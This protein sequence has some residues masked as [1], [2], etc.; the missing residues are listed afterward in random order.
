M[1]IAALVAIGL[2]I[3]ESVAPAYLPTGGFLNAV[4][5]PVIPMIVLALALLFVPGLRSLEDSKDPLA[6]V[7]PPTPP[8][9]ASARAPTMDRIIRTLWWAFLAVFVVSMLTWMPVLW[10]GVFNEGLAFSVIFPSITL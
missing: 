7:D 2:G 8:T 9:A 1:P 5:V 10:E 4:V 6:S 3:I